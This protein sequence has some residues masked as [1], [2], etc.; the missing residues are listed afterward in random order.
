[1]CLLNLFIIHKRRGAQHSAI[2]YGPIQALVVNGA[3]PLPIFCLD[4]KY[5][6][7]VYIYL[8]YYLIFIAQC[9]LLLRWPDGGI[10]NGTLGIYPQDSVY[11][12][13]AG[14][15]ILP[16]CEPAACLPTYRINNNQGSIRAQVRTP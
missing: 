15:P 11:G 6:Q 8:V 9:T 3:K 16:G 4:E 7:S 10:W 13:L 5:D 12:S 14:M 1:M 2:L